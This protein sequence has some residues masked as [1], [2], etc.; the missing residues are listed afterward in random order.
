[1]AFKKRIVSA[2]AAAVFALSLFPVSAFADKAPDYEKK[3]VTAYR[4]S[5]DKSE[6]L[7]CLFMKDLPEVPYVNVEDYLDRLYT[8][9][10]TTSSDGDVYTVSG[11]G[12]SVVTD[13]SKDT[14]TINNYDNALSENIVEVEKADVADY[15]KSGQPEVSGTNNPV[16]LDYSKYN[17][18]LIGD[19]GKV[20]FPLTTLSDIFDATYLAAEYIDNK[21]YFVQ[22]LSVTSDAD[23]YFDRSSVYVELERSQAMIDYTYNELCFLMDHFYGKPP[24]APM[25]K[26]IAE[27]GF[28]KALDDYP[29]IKT[30]LKSNKRVDF[31]MGL[32]LLS[33]A[34]DD[35]G[36]TI[37]CG[38][39]L[40]DM[41]LYGDDDSCE[42]LSKFQTEMMFDDKASE[43]IQKQ[44]TGDGTTELIEKA[45]KEKLKNATLVK[46]WDEDKAFFY[47]KDKTAIFRFDHFEHPVVRD[48]AWALDYASKKGIKNFVIDIATNGGGDEAIA[49]FINTIITNKQ[50]NNN[51]ITTNILN[52]ANSNLLNTKWTADLDLN[53][54]FDD[55]DK[56]VYYDFNY[57]M[58]T[59]KASFSSGN[60]MPCMAKDRGILI[61]GET[62]GGGT[63]MLSKHYYPDGTYYM[64][65]GVHTMLRG[66]KTNVDNGAAVDFELV[67]KAADGSKDYSNY[68]DFA[69]LEEYINKFYG[70]TPDVKPDNKNNEQPKIDPAKKEE[71]KDAAPPTGHVGDTVTVAVLLIAVGALA[72]KRK[73]E[74]KI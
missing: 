46:E 26:A 39:M 34:L 56:S 69:K 13:T 21:L 14:V 61:L 48:F 36:H 35:G 43:I 37:M 59:S 1:M 9:D 70:I 4:Y 57:A 51:V 42:M 54:V 47:V 22:T 24:K 15:I 6:T 29:E 55:K 58:L 38:G 31:Q 66:D 33:E 25:S 49:H 68:Y 73:D 23:G 3:D 53:G 5:L 65:S 10:F 67:S 2:A 17:I 64:T 41:E 19:D 8:V 45:R 7:Q 63:C 30:M 50:K 28:D 71:N 32:L 60:L 62:S 44:V 52:T 27:K 20:Y 12:F 18:D 74:D 72:V 40:A 16:N 11:N